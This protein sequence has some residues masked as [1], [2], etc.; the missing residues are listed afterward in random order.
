MHAIRSPP[1]SV[2]DEACPACCSV[3]LTVKT[4]IFISDLT[5][6]PKSTTAFVSNFSGTAT[7]VCQVFLNRGLIMHTAALKWLST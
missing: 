5:D 6:W 4:L 3:S 1:A 2:S 7:T